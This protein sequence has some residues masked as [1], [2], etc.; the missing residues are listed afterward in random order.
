MY[1]LVSKAMSLST[2]FKG[3]IRLGQLFELEGSVS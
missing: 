3:R 2:V 1:N